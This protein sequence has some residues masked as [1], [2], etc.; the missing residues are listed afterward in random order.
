MKR[1]QLALGFHNHQPHG[2]LPPVIERAFATAYEPTL[3]ALERHPKTRLTLYYSGSLLEWLRAN[4][5]DFLPRVKA[6]AARGQV[7]LLGGAMYEPILPAIPRADQIGQIRHHAGLVEELFGVRPRGMWLAER[8]WEPSLPAVLNEA[9]VQYTLVDDTHLIAAGVAT[10]DLGGVYMTE[11]QGKPVRLF[12]ISRELREMVPFREPA[13]VIEHL[14]SLARED[15][16]VL[17]VLF[18]DGEKFN[19]WPDDGR[20]A[21]SDAWLERFLRLL[22]EN[23]AWLSTTTLSDYAEREAPLGRVYPPATSYPELNLWSLPAPAA[24]EA[25]ELRA[26]LESRPGAARLAPL[27]GGGTWRGFLARYP[28]INHLQKRAAY[29]SRKVHGTPRAGEAASLHLWRAQASAP[30]WHADQGGVYLNFLRFAAYRNLIQAENAVEPRKYSWLEI[31]YE[32]FDVDG[33]EEVIAESNTLNVYFKP[34]AGGMI[35]ELDFRPKAFNLVDTLA[36]RPEAYHP[37]DGGARS[38][39]RLK[40][41]PPLQYDRYERRALIDHFVGAESHLAELVE[42]RLLELGDFTTGAF[43]ASKYRNRVTL[44]RLGHVRGPVGEP[45][46]VEVK[47]AVRILPKEG[48]LEVEYRIT[49]H[50]HV[51][52]ITRFGSEW[53]FGFL[54]GDAPDRYYTVEGRK[55]GNLLTVAEDQFVNAAGIVDEWLGV[56]V[57]FEFEGR[58]VLLWRFPV[59]TLSPGEGGALVRTYQ[60][61][62]LL[63]LWDLD[64]PVG[65]SRRVAYAVSIRER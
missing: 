62:V 1:V 11:D 26:S 40:N 63:P 15:R 31:N 48:R 41:A 33:Y 32:D 2:N 59:E 53:G 3:A 54:A 24:R 58:E 16:A 18:D 14:R 61:S 22:D 9:G 46:P 6:L 19:H 5:P 10:G 50:G 64:L 38:G 47:K 55:A 13:E 44:T 34:S 27:L 20:A 29:V 52:V 56:Q 25:R 8:V 12:P 51:D 36:R 35:T 37:Q 43:E 21:R 45:V 17:A 30:Y 28:E 65:R 49:N 7:E 23:S 57:E 60:S 4:R 39:K 42:G